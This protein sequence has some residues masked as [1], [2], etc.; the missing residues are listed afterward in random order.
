MENEK[1]GL[2]RELQTLATVT[3]DQQACEVGVTVGLFV[4]ENPH[5]R[6]L[7]QE[8]GFRHCNVVKKMI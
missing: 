6:F 2:E 5:I 8:G 1:R 7:C 3:P 4:S